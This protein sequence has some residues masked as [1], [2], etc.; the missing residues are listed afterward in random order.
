MGQEQRDRGLATAA[1]QAEEEEGKT[2][3]TID[4]QMLTAP[5]RKRL[6]VLS[7]NGQR[8][9]VTSICPSVELRRK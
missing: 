5:V 8:E 6:C 1:T 3:S 7:G 2:H 4:F 9:G